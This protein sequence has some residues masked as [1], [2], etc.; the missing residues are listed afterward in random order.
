MLE[1]NTKAPEFELRDQNGDSH[2]LSD[3]SGQVRLIYFYPKDN[4]PGCSREACAIRDAYGE[5]KKAGIKVFGISRDSIDSHKKFEKKF[6]LPFTLLSDPESS[7]IKPWGA[8]RLRIGTK[9]ISYLLDKDG[10]II[11]AYPDVTPEDHADEILKD[12]K[13]I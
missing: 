13:N 2:K 3:S 11:K 10:V 6:E 9:R 4:T 1:I 12:V 7:V 8:S 5:F